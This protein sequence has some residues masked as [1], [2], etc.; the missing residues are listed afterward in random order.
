M[1]PDSPSFAPLSSPLKEGAKMDFTC[2]I[3]PQ[4]TVEMWNENLWKICAVFLFHK[5]CGKL[6]NYP[7][8]PVDK[9]SLRQ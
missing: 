2:S 8:L 5:A 6:M 9:K 1:V 4:K 3:Y 7:K